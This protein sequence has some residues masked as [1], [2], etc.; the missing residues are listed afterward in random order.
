MKVYRN[1]NELAKKEKTGRR[2]SM[3]GLVVLFLGLLA[4]F[5][6]TWYPPTTPNQGGAVGLLQDYWTWLSLIALAAGFFLASAGSYYINRYA[7]R[8]WPGSKIIE[9]PDEVLERNMK[10]FDDKFCLFALSLPPNYVLAG[11]NGV[12]VFTLRGDKGRVIVDGDKWREPF[13]FS[14]IFTFFAREGVGNPS[15]DLAEQQEQIRKLLAAAEP[16]VPEAAAPAGKGATAKASPL[17]PISLADV[18]ING[19]A[20]FLNQDAQLELNNPTVPALRV[21]QIKDYIRGRAKEVKLSNAT[22][23]ALNEF[24]VGQAAFQEELTD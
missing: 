10:G 11:P 16:I 23:R 3:A 19:A 6:P 4:S 24:L 5:V 22:Q 17:A 8:R 9:R 13:T 21:D 1:T 12:T 15:R 7:R 14:R 20:I 18:P 2:F